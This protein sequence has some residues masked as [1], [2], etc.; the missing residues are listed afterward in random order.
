MS[1]YSRYNYFSIPDDDYYE[2]QGSFRFH[3]LVTCSKLESEPFEKFLSR[4]PLLKL[5]IRN[6]DQVMVLLDYFEKKMLGY[7]LVVIAESFILKLY[8]LLT[9]KAVLNFRN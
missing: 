8:L 4:F 6:N 9:K 3:D 5:M 7:G 1:F 2:I